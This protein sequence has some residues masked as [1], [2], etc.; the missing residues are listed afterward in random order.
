LLL[1]AVARARFDL[2]VLA[3]ELSVP[4]LSLL[5]ALWVVGLLATSLAAVLGPRVGPR[6]C[7]RSAAV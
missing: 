6:S 1:H 2:A 7:W 3:L 4:P 5:G